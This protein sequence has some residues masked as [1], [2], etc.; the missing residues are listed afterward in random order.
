MCMLLITFESPV[1]AYIP[2]TQD[3]RYIRTVFRAL[4]Q[5]RDLRIMARALKRAKSH[6]SRLGIRVDTKI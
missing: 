5:W 1:F 4:Y 3:D 2:E 6:M